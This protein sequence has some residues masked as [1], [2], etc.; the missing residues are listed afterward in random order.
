MLALQ[1]LLQNILLSHKSTKSNLEFTLSL[2]RAITVLHRIIKCLNRIM[3]SN[4]DL[5]RVYTNEFWVFT[6]ST[7]FGI[8]G[9]R[10]N[11]ICWENQIGEQ[12]VDR[13]SAKGW[14]QLAKDSHYIWGSTRSGV[15][16]QIPQGIHELTDRI[17]PEVILQRSS[18]Q[19]I[20]E[21][22]LHLWYSSVQTLFRPLQRCP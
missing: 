1:N 11:L 5:H 10:C 17:R 12:P 21:A 4:M 15:N 2:Y 9:A 22:V 14:K 20:T 13:M 3:H 18:L 19:S 8:G 16:T 6:A 7:W